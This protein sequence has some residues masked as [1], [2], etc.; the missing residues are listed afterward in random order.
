MQACWGSCHSDQLPQGDHHAV[1]P[2][3]CSPGGQPRAAACLFEPCPFMLIPCFAS[4]SGLGL[5]KQEMPHCSIVA[6]VGYLLY[7]LCLSRRRWHGLCQQARTSVRGSQPRRRSTKKFRHCVGI[8]NSTWKTLR[9]LF[10]LLS[11]VP[12]SCLHTL[13]ANTR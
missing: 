9:V 4:Y 13:F 6:M 8:G 7:G 12:A 3:D 2:P 1:G 5:P 10:L 11:Y